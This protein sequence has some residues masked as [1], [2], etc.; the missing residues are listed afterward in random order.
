MRSGIWVPLAGLGV[1]IIGTVVVWISAT[2]HAREPTTRASSIE[3]EGRS[4]HEQPPHPEAQTR[5]EPTCDGPA[6]ESG[7]R[8]VSFVTEG[9][10][11]SCP[12]ATSFGRSP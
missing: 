3:A 7:A 5:L 9:G 10:Q 8:L 1:A 12:R 11:V 6:L 2:A 4:T